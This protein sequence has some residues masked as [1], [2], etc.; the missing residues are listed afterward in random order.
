[1]TKQLENEIKDVVRLSIHI[2]YAGKMGVVAAPDGEYVDY[3]DHLSVLA[4]R[5][6]WR[7][8]SERAFRAAS[9]NEAV[10][11]DKDKVIAEL[12]AKLAAYEEVQ[13]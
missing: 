8:K 3:A 10:I 6:H 7:T 11:E 12:R 13:S 9:M 1:M 2:D 4:S 5:D